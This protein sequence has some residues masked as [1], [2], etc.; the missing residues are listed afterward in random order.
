MQLAGV[1]LV[2]GGL[3]LILL[4]MA[5]PELDHHLQTMK[6]AVHVLVLT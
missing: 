6:A 3:L 5:K 4:T 2:T 1:N